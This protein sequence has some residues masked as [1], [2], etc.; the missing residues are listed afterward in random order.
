MVENGWDIGVD[1]TSFVEA[2]SPT[3]PVDQFEVILEVK[4]YTAQILTSYPA[5]EVKQ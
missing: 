5:F 4:G 1:E 3:R 2:D